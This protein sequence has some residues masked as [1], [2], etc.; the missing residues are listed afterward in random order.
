MCTSHKSE[1]L[2]KERMR[3]RPK[4]CDRYYKTVWNSNPLP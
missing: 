1:E 3:G 2:L 4:R